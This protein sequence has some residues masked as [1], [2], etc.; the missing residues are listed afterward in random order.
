MLSEKQKD[1]Y[2]VVKTI[3]KGKVMTYG[4]VAK[5]AG[6]KNPRLVGKYLHQNPD[7]KNIPC[8]RV[9]NYRGEVAG[10]YAFGGGQ[11]QK[12]RLL[13]EGVKFKGERVIFLLI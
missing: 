10:N 2:L 5:L 6:I 11:I 1:V 12:N 13:I 8:H 9:V 3:P 4:Q 7:P